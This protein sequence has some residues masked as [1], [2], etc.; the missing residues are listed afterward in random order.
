MA[1]EALRDFGRQRLRVAVLRDPWPSSLAEDSLK[2]G[3]Q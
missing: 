1:K 2:S 3:H